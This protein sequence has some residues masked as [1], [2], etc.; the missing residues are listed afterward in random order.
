MASNRNRSRTWFCAVQDAA[1][2]A[3]TLLKQYAPKPSTFLRI[4]MRCVDMFCLAGLVCLLGCGQN[5]P[6]LVSQSGPAKPSSS[7]LKQAAKNCGISLSYTRTRENSI[8]SIRG[9][10]IYSDPKKLACLVRSNRKA[11]RL[12]AAPESKVEK[13][14]RSSTGTANSEKK[15]FNSRH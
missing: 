10:D 9:R 1:T 13:S 8:R 7:A 3:I 6:E 5:N 4:Q 14:V 15:E 2:I 11:A 12:T